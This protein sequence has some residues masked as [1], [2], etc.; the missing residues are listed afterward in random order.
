M[1]IEKSA[2]Y[3]KLWPFAK[4]G[5]AGKGRMV[6]LPWLIISSQHGVQCPFVPR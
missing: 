5:V 3:E 6:M 2:Q 1:G 4:A